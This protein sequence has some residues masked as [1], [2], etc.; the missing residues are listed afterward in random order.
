MTQRGRVLRDTNAGPGLLTVDG[1]QYSFTL[2]DMWQSELPPRMGMIVEV[3]FN[4]D[5]APEKVSMMPEGQ[6]AREQA[7]AHLAEAQK[8]SGEIASNMVARFGVSVLVAEGLLLLGWF[9]LPFLSVKAM[10]LS[11]SVT[12]WQ[13]LSYVGTGNPLV[14]L[15][16]N[17][18]I[19]SSGGSLY[20]LLGVVCVFGP[21]LPYLW[22]DRRAVFGDLLPLAFL[23]LMTAVT[24]S[25]LHEAIPSGTDPMSRD[26]ASMALDNILKSLSFGIGA[27]LSAAVAVY[28]AFKGVKTYLVTKAE[29]T[30]A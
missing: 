30:R 9:F 15:G 4:G 19:S 5:G 22:K 26:M 16:G 25:A 13:V 27:Y 11:R 7:A 21:L 18:G 10:Y 1:K 28:L 20:E 29:G 3:Q 17:A 8:R 23:L 14:S 6:V 24:L 2:E 12:L